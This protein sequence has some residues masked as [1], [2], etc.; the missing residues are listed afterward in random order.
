MTKAQLLKNIVASTQLQKDQVEKVLSSLAEECK[1]ALFTEGKFEVPGVAK[2][3]VVKKPATLATT[4]MNPFTR[5]MVEVAAK[6]ESKK[7][8]ASPVK[9]LKD[10]FD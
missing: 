9:L 5:A 1:N 10:M 8:K 6:P 2:L 4:R 3:K 7:V